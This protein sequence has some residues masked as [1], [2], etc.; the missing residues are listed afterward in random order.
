MNFSNEDPW[1]GLE[2]IGSPNDA[3]ANMNRVSDDSSGQIA[4]PGRRV[5]AVSSITLIDSSLSA[6]VKET[7]R[8]NYRDRN[9]YETD[10]SGLEQQV[11]GPPTEVGKAMN[12][13]VLDKIDVPSGAGEGILQEARSEELSNWI[14]NLRK[15]YNPLS[16][17][18]VVVEEILEREGLL[19][20]H[21]NYLVKHLIALPNTT[22]SS[23]RTVIRR[24]SDFNWLQ[25]VLLKKY[26]F[27]MIPELPPKKIGAQ[28]A[29]PIFLVRRRKGLSR[30]INLVMKHP[31]LSFDDLVLTFL[32]VPTDL[33]S[34]RKQANYDTTE[35][36]T[37]QKIDKAFINMWQKELGNQW[38]EA[39]VKIDALLESWIKISVLVDR[40][41][42]RMKQ[43]S[44]ERRLLGSVMEEFAASTDALY[45][46]DESSIQGVNSHIKIISNHLN[47]LAD[48]SKKELNEVDERLSVKFKTFIDIII[49]L[50]GVFE[51]YKIMAGNNI[52]QLQRKLEINMEKLQ[53]LSNKPDVKGAEYERIKQIVQRDK[54]TIAEQV[55]RSWLI[56]KGI[57]EEF[58]I[59]QETQF[60]VTHIF[61]EWARMHVGFSNE[62]S[63]CW[64]KLY[65]NLEDMPLSRN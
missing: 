3:W 44:D 28:N 5:D 35:E 9:L 42:R 60:F 26:P 50:R 19:F 18:I 31:V 16:S 22:P 37:D 33:G 17:D 7:I 57:L 24:Y 58:T 10:S 63:E 62:N 45:P 25:E 49:S 39:D 38:N 40:Y 59:F 20:K 30:F 46:L 15:T 41:E 11:W 14:D 29:D 27:R 2:T 43:I 55:N 8:N 13:S 4:V 47:Q 23:N 6:E 51:R 52:P 65:T 12:V 32:T 53:T 34:W 64:E 56:R 61:Q 48:I 21:T 54:R 36:F 1:K